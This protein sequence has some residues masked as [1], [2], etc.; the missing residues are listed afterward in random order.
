MPEMPMKKLSGIFKK[1][2][3]V[4]LSIIAVLTMATVTWVDRTPYI[5]LDFYQKMTSEL[6]DVRQD[7]PKW[8]G[9]DTLLIGW[10]QVNLTPYGL[11]PLAGYGNRK[12]KEMTAVHD[13]IFVNTVI[14]SNGTMKAALVT[15]DLL[16]IHPEIT[17][18]L[19]EKLKTI[20]WQL[21]QVFLTAT[22][23]HSSMGG[24]A[25]GLVGNLIAGTYDQKYVQHIVDKMILSIQIAE[26]TLNFGAM[27]YSEL[28]VPSL[29]RNRLVGAEGLVDPSLKILGLKSGGQEGLHLVFSAHATCLGGTN[30]E[31]SRDYPGILV[32]ELINQTNLTYAAYSAGAVASMGP[33]SNDLRQ[34]EGS[35]YLGHELSAQIALLQQFGLPY[36]NDLKLRSLRFPLFLRDPMV[37]IS[38]HLAL[39]PWIFN[40]AFG[41]YAAE[42]SLLQLN[43]V[44][45]IGLPCDF[46][47]E[48]AMELYE[49]AA[50]KQLH[51]ILTSF[52]GG[53]IGYVPKDKWYDLPKYE[54]R[55]MSWYGFDNG[56]YFLEMIKMLIDE[57][58]ND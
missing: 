33:N 19:E 5:E 40:W 4:L 20:D 12:P 42:I 34:F 14:F 3:V 23:S 17:N 27:G 1:T 41:E 28:I 30:H 7:F 31:M 48:L 2:L 36:Q 26:A 21:S 47:G 6:K 39:R 11:V 58:H 13:S 35:N 15:A 44:L 52:N 29:V 54:T 57:A 49:Y 45:M 25:P 56:A 32:D 10:S 50:S 22:H 51:L 46:S 16:I 38:Q 53:Y 43:D 55:S 37:K 8:T 24:W 9:G 18:L